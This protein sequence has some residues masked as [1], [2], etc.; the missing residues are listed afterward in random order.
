MC[1]HMC[2]CKLWVATQ[3]VCDS[4]GLLTAI[5]SNGCTG[6]TACTVCTQVLPQAAGVCALHTRNRQQADGQAWAPQHTG[7]QGTGTNTRHTHRF[8]LCDMTRSVTQAQLQR[9]ITVEASMQAPFAAAASC[10][11]R[12]PWAV[13]LSCSR[14][15]TAA[16]RPAGKRLP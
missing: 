13:M 12:Q 2:V 7:V 15:N 14:H 11:E 10:L 3:S 5:C 8:V 6:R 16:L 9:C 1:I 4:S